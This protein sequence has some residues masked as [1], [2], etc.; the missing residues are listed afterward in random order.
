MSWS[1]G[2]AVGWAVRWS[3]DSGLGGATVTAASRRT[4]VDLA[5]G[6]GLP[7][8]LAGADVIVH[9]A[10]HPLKYRAVDLEGTRRIIRVLTRTARPAA[11]DLR[12]HRR[13]RPQPL[14]LLPGQVRLR[15]GPG[16]Q[17][18]AGHGGPGHPVPHPRDHASQA[19]AATGRSAWCRRMSFQSCDHRWVAE[20]LVDTAL[21]EPPP[22]YRRATDLAGTG[23]YDAGRGGEPGPARRP[24]SRRPGDHA[25]RRRR[26]AAGVRPRQP[27]CRARTPRSAGRR[28]GIP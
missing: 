20:R 2:A 28:S 13:L 24:A 15:A 27:T 6:E 22:A 11:P 23:A 1:P 3:A 5:T 9:A 26:H 12:L 10:R 4:G 19:A 8:A 21:A 17:W 7:A 25:A 14:S 18:S 16:A